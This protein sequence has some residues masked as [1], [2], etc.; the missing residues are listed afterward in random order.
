MTRAVR[1]DET[2]V[3]DLTRWFRGGAVGAGMNL[4]DI[5]PATV[6]FQALPQFDFISNTSVVDGNDDIDTGAYEAR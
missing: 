6:G 2:V 1:R 5:E 3:G 4:V